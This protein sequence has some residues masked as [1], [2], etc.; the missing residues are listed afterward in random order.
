MTA[1]FLADECLKKTP[2]D[3]RSSGV[4]FECGTG[5]NALS[6]GIAVCLL[7]SL[8]ASAVNLFRLKEL[9]LRCIS[10]VII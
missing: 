8:F 6:S 1:G 2:D 4:F 9:G 3:V 5:D 7:L 10:S